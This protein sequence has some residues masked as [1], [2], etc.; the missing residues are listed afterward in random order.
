MSSCNAQTLDPRRRSLV[1]IGALH[2]APRLACQRRVWWNG[3]IVRSMLAPVVVFDFDGTLVHGDSFTRFALEYLLENRWRALLVL[4]CLPFVAALML[5]RPTLSP[6]V[7]LFCWSLTFGLGQRPFV[8]ALRRFAEKTL[9]RY[10][11]E[12]ALA[13]LSDRLA[14]G[15]TIVVAT[16][17]PPVLVRT[18]LRAR[19]LAGVRIAGTRLVR[20]AG[21]LVTRP[22]CIGE[23][24]LHELRRKFGLTEWDHVYTDSALDLPLARRA[25]AVTLV[26]ASARTLRRFEH[27][28][29]RSA[30]VR[31][32][33]D[34]PRRALPR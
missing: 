30:A 7:S 32:L 17:A 1:C 5:F 13:E 6:G 8:A 22:H 33:R 9:P 28:L 19:R 24:K 27:T 10:V 14:R 23:T 25:C 16:A 31:V 3:C 20:C 21:G 11:N 4:P 15:E 18:L 34:A 12:R 29:G 2:D 26:E